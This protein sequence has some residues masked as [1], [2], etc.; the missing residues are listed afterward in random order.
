[1]LKTIDNV[2][3]KDN[4]KEYD[5]LY[6]RR[7][8][9]MTG[10]VKR[11]LADYRYLDKKRNHTMCD[12]TYDELLLLLSTNKCT[13]CNSIDKLGLDRIDNTKGHTKDNTV[14]CCSACN[15]LKG[16]RY[17]KENMPIISN[18]IQKR[19][20]LEKQLFDIKEQIRSFYKKDLPQV[21][22]DDE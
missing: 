21:K 20:L 8:N 4:P 5:R 16:D 15:T 12:Y 10:N 6:R 13:Y 1:M 18:L 9:S 11:K 17:A 14:V 22:Y 3:R 7:Y 2:S 19:T